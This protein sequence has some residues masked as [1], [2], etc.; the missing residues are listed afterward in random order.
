MEQPQTFNESDIPEEWRNDLFQSYGEVQEP[1]TIEES[2]AVEMD[3][4]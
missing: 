3:R 4:R 1:F 2:D